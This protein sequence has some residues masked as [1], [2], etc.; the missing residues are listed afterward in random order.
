MAKTATQLKALLKEKDLPAGD[1]AKST[2]VDRLLKGKKKAPK[3][4]AERQATHKANRS[5]AKKEEDT[6]RNTEHKTSSRKTRSEAKKEEDRASNAMGMAVLRGDEN[7]RL[8]EN[9]RERLR[10]VDWRKVPKNCKKEK[11]RKSE[12]RADATSD[13]NKIKDLTRGDLTTRLW[14]RP[15]FDWHTENHEQHWQAAVMKLYLCAGIGWD[16][17]FRWEVAFI[18]VYNRLEKTSKAALK[19]EEKF[20]CQFNELNEQLMRGEIKALEYGCALNDALDCW[21]DGKPDLLKKRGEE[22]RKVTDLMK[23]AQRGEISGLEFLSKALPEE[24]AMAAA[25]EIAKDFQGRVK[26]TDKHRALCDQ[27]SKGLADVTRKIPEVLG[28][29]HAQESSGGLVVWDVAI[30]EDSGFTA[31]ELSEEAG[32]VGLCLLHSSSRNT[33]TFV[34]PQLGSTVADALFK[35]K[36]AV[37]NQ[38]LAAMAKAGTWVKKKGEA[39]DSC[40]GD[41]WDSDDASFGGRDQGGASNENCIDG[42]SDGEKDS[43][44]WGEDACISDVGK[45]D[46]DFMQAIAASIADLK[47]ASNLEIEGPNK[48]DAFSP[49]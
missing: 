9:E 33:V 35:F 45:D 12:R 8:K 15:G 23:Q 21:V 18:H 29:V 42:S 22:C 6:A 26:G 38:K 1:A 30:K 37:L 16:E 13:L 19:Q 24:D 2:L 40:G 41:E 11:A 39:L 34:A 17:E 7:H 28:E 5:D 44:E 46:G 3:S 10:K 32:N 4:N 31:A 25:V 20:Y 48:V 14:K 36:K 43:E 27:V 49:C 47:V